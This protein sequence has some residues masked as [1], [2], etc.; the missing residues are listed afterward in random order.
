MMAAFD[1]HANQYDGVDSRGYPTPLADRAAVSQERVAAVLAEHEPVIEGSGGWFSC[2]CR[3]WSPVVSPGTTYS[4][5]VAAALAASGIGGEGER[6]REQLDAQVALGLR[7]HERAVAAEATVGRVTASLSDAITASL[8]AEWACDPL[9]SCP[10]YAHVNP[11]WLRTLIA[12]ASA[13]RAALAPGGEA[14][15]TSGGGS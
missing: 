3:A 1:E 13:V 8:P 9:P 12:E 15:D 2:A 11:D 6:L 5:H 14:Q 7:Y 4:D 10:H